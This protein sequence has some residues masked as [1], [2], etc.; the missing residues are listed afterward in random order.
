MTKT[1]KVKWTRCDKALYKITASDLL[2][3]I[4]PADDSPTLEAYCATITEAL[5]FAAK[6]STPATNTKKPR[7]RWTGDI[8]RA[9]A[10]NREAQREWRDAG[11]PDQGPV[12]MRKTEMKKTLRQKIRQAN[13]Q[14]RTLLYEQIMQATPRDVKLFHSLIQTQRTTKSSQCTDLMVN[15]QLITDPHELLTAWTNHF[16]RLATPMNSASF[17]TKYHQ[18]VEED[19]LILQML[20]AENN[21]D[22]TDI[23]TE[24]VRKAISSLNSGNAADLGG[25]CSEH[26]KYAADVISPYLASLFNC[27][28]S[29]LPIPSLNEAYVLPIH[30]KGKD[31]LLMDN[32][33]GITITSTISKALEHVILQ[34]IRPCLVQSHLQFG[35]TQGLSPT[36]AILMVNE[37]IAEAADNKQPLYAITLDAR[38]AFDV[39]DH[40]SLIR[41]LYFNGT[42]LHSLM[43]IINNL[44]TEAKVKLNGHYGDPFVVQQG[45]GQGK[46][47]S[48]HNYKTYGNDLLLQLEECASGAHIANNYFG[49]P[50]CAD[51]II[52][53]SNNI[54]DLQT[55]LDIASL[56]ANKERY[57]I[58]PGKSKC[59]T[60]N[61]QYPGSPQLNGNPI[62]V[63]DQAT[64]LGIVRVTNS[65]SP[66]P[67]IEDRISLARRT[68]YSLMGTGFHGNNGISPQYSVRIYMTY[69]IPRM[70]YG[71]EAVTL[72]P[73]HITSLESFH[74]KTIRELQSLPL[75]TA[76]EAVYLLS[77]IPPLECILDSSIAT[78]HIQIGKDQQHPLTKSGLVQ[79]STKHLQSNSWFIYSA[80]R[81]SRYGIS[82]TELLLNKIKKSTAKKI[83]LDYWLCQLKQDA[84]TKSSLL[85]LCLDS[86]S[87]S[88]CHSVWQNLECNL[89]EVKKAMTKAKLLVGAYTLQCNKA[90][91]N[92][93]EVNPTCP[94]CSS[95]EE[96]RTHLLLHCEAMKDIRSKHMRIIASIVPDF[97]TLLDWQKI[98][99]ILDG[100]FGKTPNYPVVRDMFNL[101]AATRTYVF[102]LHC[103]RIKLIN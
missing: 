83:I 101:E 89:S 59:I 79:L 102:S 8:S 49:S 85:H 22:F 81:L 44:R 100:N 20:I 27:V 57:E 13:A 36:L 29:G 7:K 26:L 42:D 23:T 4:Y 19:V 69:V 17:D 60:Y 43:F 61:I 95:G 56:Y 46:I 75:R 1:S 94:L 58:H 6:V 31:K 2:P 51:D 99:L 35:F 87:L 52:L 54:I 28:L 48:T 41:K 76:K 24:E 77:G 34:R 82:T 65:A 103:R 70:M 62:E 67:V 71:L 45:V 72:K 88:K 14:K 66:D 18:L 16:Q 97:D 5:H 68:A 96:D 98:N 84:S 55:Q 53:L 40:S 64:H 50:T 11:K 92:Q 12:F 38:K 86:C 37:A 33:R 9:M 32:Y 91:F 21:D 25:L 93:Y 39:V 10:C 74:R 15:D 90:I 30:K 73:K 47:I 80:R 3:E 78:L 63:T